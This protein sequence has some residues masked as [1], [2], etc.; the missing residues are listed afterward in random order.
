M[1]DSCF[2]LYDRLAEQYNDIE[3]FLHIDKLLNN[4]KSLDKTGKDMLY[5]LI[6]I[7]SLRNSSSKILEIPY[8][9]EKIDNSDKNIS[10]KFD[11]K[12]FPNKLKH[13]IFQFTELHLQK[14]RE[15]INKKC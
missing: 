10:L 7:H 12:N 13:I 3:D 8:G 11:L 15:D 2:P 6:R 9:G 14:M 4:I 5:I 1:T